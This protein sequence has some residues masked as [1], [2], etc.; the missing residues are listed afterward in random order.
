MGMNLATAIIRII[1]AQENPKSGTVLKDEEDN[2]R[3]AL[4]VR[5]VLYWN[6]S[7][8]WRTS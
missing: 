5:L 6:S 7:S 4:P 3:A 8:D 2:K 1:E